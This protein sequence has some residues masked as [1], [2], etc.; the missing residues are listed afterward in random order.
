MSLTN[1]CWLYVE[2]PSGQVGAENFRLETRTVPEIAPGHVL[3]KATYIS[4]DPY[5]RIQQSAKNT[6]EAPFPV[7]KVQQGGV[8]GEVI[9]SNDPNG[10][11]QVGDTVN[12]YTGWQRYG[13][14]AADSV[15]KID[16]ADLPASYGLS[17]LGMPG[18][19]AYFGLMEVGRPESGNTLL[20]SGAAGAVG[21][22]VGQIGRLVGC[23]VVGIAGGPEKCRFLVEELRFDDAIDYKTLGDQAAIEAALD[24]D[25]HCPAG[26]DVY[27]DNV[28]GVIT[29]AVIEK[30]NVRARI[31]ICGQI[32]QYNG[33]LD[34]PEMGPRF[35]HHLLYKRARI[36]GVLARDYNDR[37]DEMMARMVPWLQSGDIRYR[38]TIIEGFEQ[39]PHALSAMMQG[40]NIGKMVVRV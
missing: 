2:R 10:R 27:F 1:E 8:I 21:S 24:S 39:L 18:R 34:R 37:M 9:A 15:R 26:I 32:S 31:V 38:E 36:E 25:K 12:A 5:M 20:V 30:I 23:R 7:G 29:D 22:I 14:A 16:F 6:W 19:T 28:G 4:V 35:L 13:I 3:I 11:I 17:V 40:A 33:G